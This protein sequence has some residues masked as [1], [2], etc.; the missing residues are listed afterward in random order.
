MA[1]ALVYDKDNVRTAVARQV[2]EHA[3][4]AGIVDEAGCGGTVR[5]LGKRGLVSGSTGG[6]GHF[7][8]DAAGV[9]DFL[10]EAWLSQGGLVAASSNVDAK[11]T[12]G[13]V[14]LAELEVVVLK[15]GDKGG[16]EGLVGRPDEQ[17]IN[18]DDHNDLRAQEKA[19]IAGRRLEAL[20]FKTL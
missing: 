17:V 4:D 7:L 16:D 10:G 19:G 12:F 3:D 6:S 9:D 15:V 11:D 14:L 1:G 8:V 20:A 2:E 5:V 18:V 13:S